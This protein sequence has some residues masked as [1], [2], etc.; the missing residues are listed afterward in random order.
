MQEIWKDIPNYE[1]FYQVSNLGRVKSLA[2]E[3]LGKRNRKVKEKIIDLVQVGDIVLYN[4]NCKMTDIEIVKEHIDARTQKKTL[5][6]G[7]WSLKQVKIKG[8]LTKEQF[9]FGKYIVG[10]E[11]NVKD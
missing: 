5:R 11:S 8:I 2:R 7:L 10:D 4:I 6:V 9:D 3:I 1:G